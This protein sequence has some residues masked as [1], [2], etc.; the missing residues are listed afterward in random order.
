MSTRR[1]IELTT[2]QAAWI[3]GVSAITIRVWVKR[4][5]IT[6]SRPG[7]IDAASLTHY[8]DNRGNHGQ[9]KGPPQ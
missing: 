4:G 7:F 8:L 1:P 5:R 9:R 3:A 6:R 2:A